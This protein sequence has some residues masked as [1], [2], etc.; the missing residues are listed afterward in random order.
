MTLAERV[1]PGSVRRLLRVFYDRWH[2]LI[3]E[4]T[5]FGI[6]GVFNTALDFV[7]F[8]AL[9]FGLG[10]GPLTSQCLSVVVSA[11][12]SYFMN[13]HWTFRHRARSGLRR[14]YML[15]FLFNG[16]GL[17]I[18]LAVLA[19][20]RYGMGLEDPVSLNIAKIVGLVLGTLFRFWSYRRWVFLHPEDRLY[21]TLDEPDS[22]ERE[23][24][25][26]R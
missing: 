14:E 9:H 24:A 3:R 19:V 2:H 8:N 4:M 7:V 22:D 23:P 25:A 17:A 11:T 10:I 20:T 12:S 15:F 5:K 21:A 18:A 6:I 26:T 1:Y 16:V 13:R